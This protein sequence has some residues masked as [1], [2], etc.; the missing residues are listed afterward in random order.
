[1]LDQQSQCWKLTLDVSGDGPNNIG[2]T[3][4]QVYGLS[5]FDR[6]NINALVIG[7]PMGASGDGD[8]PA[9]EVLRQYFEDEV[10]RG[11]DAFSIV[12]NGYGDYADAMRRKLIREMTLPV[13]G[14]LGP[15]ESR[16]PLRIF[17]G[18]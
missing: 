15:D 10:I 1:M 11:V 5:A 14:Q 3:P 18:N 16:P 6:V 7:N 12:A 17:A 13:F 9:P 4:Q 8:G 2:P